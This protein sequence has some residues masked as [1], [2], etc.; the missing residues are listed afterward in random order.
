MTIAQKKARLNGWIKEYQGRIE[1]Y[2]L[3]HG[4][5]SFR[6]N[7]LKKSCDFKIQSWG[8]DISNLEKIKNNKP[9]IKKYQLFAEDYFG[10]ILVFKG[11]R[12]V[13]IYNYPIKYFLVKFLIECGFG[14]KQIHEV[15][16]CSER[17]LY[18][19]RDSATRYIKEDKELRLEYKK[20]K[21][22]MNEIKL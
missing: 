9:L 18:S 6:Y 21:K 11:T 16:N 17:A 10:V 5:R 12:D 8:K 19:N 22:R 15:L 20:F 1:R 2:K 4:E 13:N 7:L 14:G 3:E